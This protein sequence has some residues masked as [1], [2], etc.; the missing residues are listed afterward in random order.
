[1][2]QLKLAACFI[3]TLAIVISLAFFVA[4][5]AYDFVTADEP[6]AAVQE[7]TLPEEILQVI[8]TEEET[9]P[10]DTEPP[11]QETIPTETME[12]LETT[13]PADPNAPKGHN[14]VPLYF[15]TD[16]PDQMYGMGTMAS[17]G[18]SA[19][20][21]AMVA[22]YLTG[23]DYTPDD[24]GRYFGGAAENNIKRLE[25]G[26]KT[27]Q[28]PYKKSLNWHETYEALKQGKVAI[29]LMRSESL[30]TDSQ[31]FIVLTGFNEEGKIMVNDSYEPNYYKWDL[32]KA[33]R[34]G[35]DQEDIMLGYDGAW[36]YDKAKIPE[37]P[38]FYYEPEPARGE[39]RYDFELTDE[40]KT[41][42][43]KVVWVEARGE[44]MKGQQAVAEVILNRLVS[45]RFAD[46]IRGIIFSENQFK[47]AKFLDKAQPYQMQYEAVESAFYGPY[48]LPD[49]VFYFAT[50]AKTSKV[51]GEIGGHVF[52]YAEN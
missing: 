16:Y 28:L 26:S 29:A 3:A 45:G 33:F 12:V 4:D 32:E 48:I 25:L 19:T 41:L 23:H 1:M 27:L 21:L 18:C 17:N 15:Q 46:T 34:E 42:L 51:W 31:H 10:E 6:E 22:S 11:I 14:G 40:E 9:V 20:S 39:C 30:F 35:F 43:A 13:E 5:F 44:S 8:P 38:I 49:D 7:E 52:C 36:I 2:R 24:L 37:N 50:S 47:S